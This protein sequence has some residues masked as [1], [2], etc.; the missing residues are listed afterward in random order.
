MS[1]IV[2][3]INHQQEIKIYTIFLIKQKSHT[4]FKQV[5]VGKILTIPLINFISKHLDLSEYHHYISFPHVPPFLAQF[6]YSVTPEAYVFRANL[7]GYKKE[8]VKVQVEDD[9]VLNISG[10]KKTV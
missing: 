1:K 8:E 3:I 6:Q 2:I 5:E 7:H 10:E 9:R 4:N